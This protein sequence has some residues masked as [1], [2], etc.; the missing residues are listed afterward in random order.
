M[1]LLLFPDNTVLINFAL[2]N[3]MDLLARLVQ[4]KGA[5]CATV[6]HE[7]SASSS[8]AG[9]EALSEA[10][11]IFGSPLYPEGAEHLDTR[12]FREELASPGD[13]KNRH[14]GE[15]ETLAIMLRRQVKGLFVTDDREATR[16]ANRNGVRVATTWGLL[17][18][19]RRQD[20]V[21]RDTLWGYVQT[22]RANQRGTPPGVSDRPSFEK[23]L[24]A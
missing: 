19:A 12:A 18:L 10:G 15:A 16:L 5:W 7:C 9:L 6:A 23:W 3:R 8:V 17:R 1:T 20:W 2:I 24:D 13:G 4:G 22:L 14:L 11:G 21:D